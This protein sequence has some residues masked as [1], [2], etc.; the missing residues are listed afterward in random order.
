MQV[1]YSYTVLDSYT[2]L[3]IHTPMLQRRTCSDSIQVNRVG[4]VCARRVAD[5]KWLYVYSKMFLENGN[6]TYTFPFD[7]V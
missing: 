3:Y 4:M 5:S 7:L 1:L 6:I 2:V